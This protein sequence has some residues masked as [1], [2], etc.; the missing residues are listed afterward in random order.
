M[1]CERCHKPIKPGQ[2]YEPHDMLRPT[3]ACPTVIVHKQLCTRPPTQTAPASRVG[4][5]R[6]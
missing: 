4:L 6:D 5:I 3:G 2:P 1:M